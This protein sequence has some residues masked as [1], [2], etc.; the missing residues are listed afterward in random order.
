MYCKALYNYGPTIPRNSKLAFFKNL[1]FNTGVLEHATAS[2]APSC[3]PAL[4]HLQS[5]AAVVHQNT[6]GSRINIA[7]LSTPVL[8]LAI[9]FNV[10]C[11]PKTR[12]KNAARCIPLLL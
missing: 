4:A 5:S 6:M 11:T 12:K 3:K 1:I 2:L 7:L 8:K 9:T 10:R